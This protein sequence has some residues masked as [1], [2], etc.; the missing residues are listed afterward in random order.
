MFARSKHLEINKSLPIFEDCFLELKPHI[1][2]YLSI[3]E[4]DDLIFINM[5]ASL[6]KSGYLVTFFNQKAA[7]D[8][9]P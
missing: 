3:Q 9:T 8:F 2:K 7:V 4:L 5:S 6:L 1:E